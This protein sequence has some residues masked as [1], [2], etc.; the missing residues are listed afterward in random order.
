MIRKVLVPV[1]GSAFS[2]AALPMAIAVA[3]KAGAEVRLVMVSEPANLAPGAW[4]EAFLANH[5]DYLESTAE[6]VRTEAKAGTVVTSMLLE[7][8]VSKAICDEAE[9]AGADLVVMSTHGHGGLTRMWLGSTTDAVLR[10]SP[11]PVLLVRPEEDGDGP[12]SV[13]GSVGHVAVALDGSDFAEAAL[14]PGL[15]MARLFEAKVT[16]LR[17][18]MHPVLTS[19][20]LPDTVEMTEAYLERAEEEARAYLGEVLAARAI[21]SDVEVD[22]IVSQRPA[23]GILQFV[24]ESGADLVVMAS[25]GR[26]GVV[27]AVVGS[28]T[29]KVIRAGHT[30]V[31]IVHPTET[32][33]HRRSEAGT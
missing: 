33:D 4:A 20:Y 18:V 25:H 26:H 3:G 30:P 19:A 6:G 22:V 13:G 11:V 14:D 1:D 2:E 15:E 29:D 23:T 17:T 7:G 21:G 16:L 5:A 8:P 27:R 9:G 24:T 12:P 31:L 28:V 32:A 10:Q